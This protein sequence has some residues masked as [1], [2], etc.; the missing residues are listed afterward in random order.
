MIVN[1]FVI[2][3]IF[4]KKSNIKKLV[5]VIVHDGTIFIDVNVVMLVERKKQI[6]TISISILEE[7]EIFSPQEGDIGETTKEIKPNLE[8][9]WNIAIFCLKQFGNQVALAQNVVGLGFR[10]LV[11]KFIVLYCCTS[12]INW[13]AKEQ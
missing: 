3:D 5:F 10:A 7:L 2:L 8:V 4:T 9:V 1:M 6:M 13:R 11:A 12:C